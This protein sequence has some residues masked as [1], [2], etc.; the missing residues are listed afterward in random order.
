MHLFTKGGIA[1]PQAA[2]FLATLTEEIGTFPNSYY[3]DQVD[4]LVL[5]LTGLGRGIL[6]SASIEFKGSK[7]RLDGYSNGPA[8]TKK[9]ELAVPFDLKVGPWSADIVRSDLRARIAAI[10]AEP[11]WKTEP[12]ARDREYARESQP[13]RIALLKWL[14]RTDAVTTASRFRSALEEAHAMAAASDGAT[15]PKYHKETLQS[16][17]LHLAE[18]YCCAEW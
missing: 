11:H 3:D 5:A 2:P 13:V 14:D 17:A 9:H 16:Y 18:A 1:L 7:P 4:C 6:Q 12:S 8:V 10:E 15:E